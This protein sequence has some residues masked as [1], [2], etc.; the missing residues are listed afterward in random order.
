MWL[1]IRLVHDLYLKRMEGSLLD[2]GSKM[3]NLTSGT[4]ARLM[5]TTVQSISEQPATVLFFLASSASEI[6]VSRTFRSYPHLNRPMVQLL[7]DFT[8]F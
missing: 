7:H 2:D 1:S 4:Q 3:E 8:I 6:Y 5:K